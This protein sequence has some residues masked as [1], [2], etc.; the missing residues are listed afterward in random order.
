M[1]PY[2]SLNYFELLEVP[3]TATTEEILDAHRRQQEM[4]APDSVALYVLEDTTQVEELRKLLTEAMEFLSDADL[5]A[6]YHQQ[7]GLP[8]PG[9]RPEAPVQPPASRAEALP[10]PRPAPPPP[11]P[12]Q[13][14]EAPKAGRESSIPGDEGVSAPAVRVRESRISRVEF[15]PDAEF[16]GELLRRIRESRGVSLQAMVDRTRISTRHLESIE[17]DRY[18]LLPASV[19]LRGMLMSVAR[20]LG[21]DPARVAR[22]YMDL[23]ARA[24]GPSSP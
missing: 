21:L 20:E 6:E 15:S 12:V 24:S 10:P 14:E 2:Q 23:A 9:A 22:S 8:P 3:H 18:K 19:Y 4:Y 17:A 16:N 1:K 13:V 11:A 5:R 7:L